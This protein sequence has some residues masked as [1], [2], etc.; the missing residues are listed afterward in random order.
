MA[1]RAPF[2]EGEVVEVDYCYPPRDRFV[3]AMVL[4]DA[5]WPEHTWLELSFDVEVNASTG[6]LTT[7]EHQRCARCGKERTL[8]HEGFKKARELLEGAGWTVVT[9]TS[10]SL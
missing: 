10:A 4:Q 7:L 5:M 6:A 1:L 9:D 3:E 2:S 8:S